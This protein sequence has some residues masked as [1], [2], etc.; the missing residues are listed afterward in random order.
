[1]SKHELDLTLA[2]QMRDASPDEQVD[3]LFSYLEANGG[4]CYDEN[5]S[6]F[7]HALQ[8]AALAKSSEATSAQVVSA[9]LH[10]L[11]HWLLNEKEQDENFLKQDL[12]HETVAARYLEP[13]FP[14]EVT[15][16]IG[17]HVPAKRYLCTV[18]DEYY[19]ALSNA[20]KR[21]FEVQGGKLN[22]EQRAEFEET[23]H[24]EFTLQLRQW[25]DQGKQAGLQ[26]PGLENYREDVL[27]VLL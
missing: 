10:D 23:S 7:Q 17:L 25:D 12:D 9:L 19:G 8:T 6:Q 20:S 27:K 18:E 1:M 11:G 16:P 21:S 15:V 14:P 22:D 24:L 3:A 4:A 26:V 13:F 5:V 2:E